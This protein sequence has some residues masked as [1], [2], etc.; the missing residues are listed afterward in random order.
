MADFEFDNPAFDSDNLDVGDE[1]TTLIDPTDDVDIGADVG[2]G[3]TG[4]PVA[5]SLWQELL[6]TTIDD[7]YNALAEQGLIP[8]LGRDTTKF[9][10]V[11]DGRSRMKA[12]PNID[13]VVSSPLL[14]QQPW[15]G[16]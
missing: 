14:S 13:L 11:G 2:T 12:Y 3:T 8:A 5:Q 16:S 7:Y 1:E 4:T 10:L 6:Q 9:E 15:K